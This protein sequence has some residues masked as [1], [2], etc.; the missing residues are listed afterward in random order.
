MNRTFPWILSAKYLTAG[1]KSRLWSFMP[2]NS[3]SIPKELPKNCQRIA[4]EFP[5]NSQRIPKK[6]KKNSSKNPHKNY[7]KITQKL[8]KDSDFLK[9][10]N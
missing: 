10:S 7:Q 1:K 4:K 6:S 3:Q 5:K 8:P 9:M 2:E